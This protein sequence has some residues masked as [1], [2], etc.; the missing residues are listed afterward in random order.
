MHAIN[1]VIFSQ[2]SRNYQWCHLQLSAKMTEHSEWERF[3]NLLPKLANTPVSA[4]ITE[5]SEIEWFRNLLPKLANT[6]VAMLGKTKLKRSNFFWH[7][8][9]NSY[10]YTIFHLCYY[11]WFVVQFVDHKSWLTD[12][13]VAYPA[14]HSSSI[15]ATKYS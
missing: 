1:E 11:W 14:I 4:K 13:I 8:F 5:H 2:T 3:R 12:Q 15:L 9:S 7:S 10:G 6:P